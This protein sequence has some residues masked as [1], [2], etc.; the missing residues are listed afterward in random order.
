MAWACNPLVSP[1]G[2]NRRGDRMRRRQFI[3]LL[4][5]AATV[6]PLVAQGQMRERRRRVGVMSVGTEH[7]AEFKARFSAFRQRLEQLGWVEGRDISFDFRWP[8]TDA[9][10]INT[11]AADLVATNPDAILSGITPGVAA[12]QRLTR[13]I[14]IVFA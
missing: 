4:G 2:C 7:D 3:G 8:G 9:Q 1:T 10:R 11:A 5:S 13:S 6:L 12:L 14:P